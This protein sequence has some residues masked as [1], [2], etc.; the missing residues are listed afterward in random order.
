MIHYHVDHRIFFNPYAAFLYAAHNCPHK[1]VHFDVHQSSMDQVDWTRYPAAS[2]PDLY[3]KRAHQIRNKYEKIVVAFSGG[4]DSTTM[5]S[6]FF[7]NNIHV[8]AVYIGHFNDDL[9]TASYAGSP[10]KHAAWIK[11]TWPEQSRHTEIVLVN[12]QDPIGSRYSHSEWMLSQDRTCH[13]RFTTGVLPQ[14]VSEL[15]DLKYGAFR[16]AVITG[17]EKPEVSSDN[18][19][20]YFI[21]KI[22][23]HVMNRA[24]AEFFYLTADMPEIAVKQAH[25]IARFRELGN[26]GYYQLKRVIGIGGDIAGTNSQAEKNIIRQADS[27]LSQINFNQISES[28]R[29]LSTIDNNAIIGIIDGY[30]HYKPQLI[31][32]WAQGLASLQTDSTLINYMITHGYLS[33]VTQGIQSYHGIH[34]KR[35]RL[36]A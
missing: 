20:A 16:W 34:S 12:L 11:Q 18:Q 36:S 24:N 5:L 22:F 32:T 26:A 27:V 1:H 31:K 13:M 23:M 30:Q 9:S 7:D 15:F 29:K 2:Y 3:R 17:H 25:D 28:L 33:S 10:E 4:T 14:E 8:D 35:Y 6:A 19:W 21:D